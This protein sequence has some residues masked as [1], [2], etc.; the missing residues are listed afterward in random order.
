[1]TK[2]TKSTAPEKPVESFLLLTPSVFHILLT[3]ADGETH[4]YAMIGHEEHCYR[5]IVRA[6]IL[7]HET[8]HI[9]QFDEMAKNLGAQF[10]AEFKALQG[11]P[12]RMEKLRK[13][14]P[15]ETAQYQKDAVNK[16]TVGP[17]RAARMEIEAL[18]RELE[19]YGKVR[20]ALDKICKPHVPEI[21]RPQ[22]ERPSSQMYQPRTTLVPQ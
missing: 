6:A 21:E 19:F 3:L 2:E 18:N 10:L 13:Q 22:P 7:R 4:G 16:E 14:F 5:L 15:K 12:E 8:K 9:E 1:M 11:D 20:A 17:R